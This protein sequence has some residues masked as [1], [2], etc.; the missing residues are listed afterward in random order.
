MSF[1]R[2]QAGTYENGT[3]IPSFRIIVHP[4]TGIS[5]CSQKEESGELE[6][7]NAV[8]CHAQERALTLVPF[9]L[10]SVTRGKISLTLVGDSFVRA[11]PI[12]DP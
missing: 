10:T 5:P 8:D 6:S 3:D 2:G 7:H 11:K 1:A 9:W 12:G 4:V